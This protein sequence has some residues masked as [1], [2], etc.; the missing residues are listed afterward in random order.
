MSDPLLVEADP[1]EMSGRLAVLVEGRVQGVGFRPFVH[2][3]A[4]GLGLAGHVANTPEGVRIEIE[5]PAGRIDAFLEGLRRD[6]PPEAVIERLETA[7]RAPR[8]DRGFR[9]AASLLEGSGTALPTPDLATCEDCR[10]ELLDP[11]DR[12]HRYP[13]V[14]C[15]R[16][17]PRYS[18]IEALPYDRERTT[19]RRFTMCR[20]C[21]AEYEDPESRRFHAEPNACPAC[22]PRLALCDPR[23]RLLAREE[24]ALQ[25]AVRALGEGRIVAI[26]GIGGFHLAVDARDG[27]AVARLR[28]RKNRPDKPFAVMFADMAALRTACRPSREEER[29]LLD[30][31]RPIVL[32]R[33]RQGAPIAAEVAPGNP[34]LGTFLPYSPLHHLLLRDC[35]FPLVM[36]SGNRSD[37][38]IVTDEKQA[39]DRLGDIADLLLVHD[40]PILRPVEDSVVRVVAGAPVLLRLG[41]GFAPLAVPLAG[42]EPGMLAL[43]G[44]LKAGIA[45]TLPERIVLGGHLGDLESAEA[46]EVFGRETKA[47][48]R[49][50]GISPRLVLHDRHPDYAT[51]HMAGAFG[52]S[53]LAVQHHLAHIAAC[54]AEHGIAPPVLG[55]AWDGTGFGGDGTVW[56]GEFLLVASTGWRRVA[57]LRRFPLPGGER[58]VREPRRAAFGLLFTAFGESFVEDTDLPPVAAFTEGERRV[59]LRMLERGINSPRTSSVGRLFDAVASLCGLCQRAS[60]EGQAASA[61]EWAAGDAEAAAPYPFPLRPADGMLELDWQPA[62]EALLA[63]LRAGTPAGRIAARLHAGLAAAV[64][65]VAERFGIAQVVS[66]G[67]CFRNAVLLRLTAAR[68]REAGFRPVFHRRVPP[69][70]GGLALGQAAAVIG[71]WNRE[72]GGCVSPYRDG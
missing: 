41:R 64:A 39:V 24:A 21:R 67:G 29:E 3:L 36:T 48:A 18:I 32:L 7:T 35:G 69:D 63:E 31:A 25:K 58:A 27:E 57:R 20:A 40:R 52:T 1:A 2:R 28:L 65:A 45:V 12:R 44:H 13:F 51:S 22:G 16:C 4:T 11:R 71:G 54:M 68:L 72:N 50:F 53:A 46:R 10:R 30:P 70:D 5:G 23:G 6:A 33:R 15:T 56:G 17:G 61:L 14:N 42:A 55:V 8:G 37:E 26:K 59:L 38:P 34:L 47:L 19:M 49:L 9:I 62:L 66:S 60:H 43:G